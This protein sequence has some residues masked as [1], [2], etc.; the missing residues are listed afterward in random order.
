MGIRL[1]HS[2]GSKTIRQATHKGGSDNDFLLR[3]LA[4]AALDR[5]W[6]RRIR[7][8]SCALICDRLLPKSRQQALFV[9]SSRQELQ[10]EKILTA[11]DSVCNRFGNG[12]LHLGTAS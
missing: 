9:M 3:R 8:R 12:M 11:M 1:I 10:Q 2:D 6:G 4:L 5:A 7:V